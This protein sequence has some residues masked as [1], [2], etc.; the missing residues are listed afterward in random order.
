MILFW[1]LTK[2]EVWHRYKDEHTL[3]RYP[4]FVYSI[5]TNVAGAKK[6]TV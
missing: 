6:E 1:R 3:Y 2:D 5:G 4:V